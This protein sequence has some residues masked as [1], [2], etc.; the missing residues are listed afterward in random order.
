MLEKIW[1]GLKK[2]TTYISFLPLINKI[3][4]IVQAFVK[5]KNDI[6]HHQRYFNP[7]ISAISLKCTHWIRAKF[8]WTNEQ[9]SFDFVMY[10][11]NFEKHHFWTIS[12][13]TCHLKKNIC[14]L[15][16]FLIINLTESSFIFLQIR[17]TREKKDN[18]II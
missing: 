1:K 17:K 10:L 4:L 14:S 11:E 13:K 6:I 2:S 5:K 8:L 16:Y 9:D 18:I 12:F 3:I 15:Y 7:H